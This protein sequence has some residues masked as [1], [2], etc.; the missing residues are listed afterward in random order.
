MTNFGAPGTG[1][2]IDCLEDSYLI[3][4]QGGTYVL[5]AR[6]YGGL[7]RMSP[8]GI[9]D[10]EIPLTEF[11]YN[12]PVTVLQN[13]KIDNIIPNVLATNVTYSISPAL[14]EGL[15]FDVTTGIISGIP[16]EVIS[17][18][19]F[20]VTASTS[21]NSINATLNLTVLENQL[22]YIQYNLNGHTTPAAIITPTGGVSGGST[23][24]SIAVKSSTMAASSDFE[25]V[26]KFNWSGAV[27][28][29]EMVIGVSANSLVTGGTIFSNWAGILGTANNPDRV[30]IY[31][32]G[33]SVNTSLT[34]LNGENVYKL[35][36]VG[37]VITHYLNG[38]TVYKG[39]STLTTAYPTVRTIGNAVC[40]ETLF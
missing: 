15:N 39:T 12:S 16:T 29:S 27:S 3:F 28:I 1:F 33:A 5:D 24:T 8:F 35:K 31:Q 10:N 4:T 40:N 36:R 23:S 34:L 9:I 2:L 17:A 18:T 11:S 30:S 6:P 19:N 14:P 20:T 7:L 37:S 22:S 13:V 32:N 26:W 25:Y 38:V 21:E